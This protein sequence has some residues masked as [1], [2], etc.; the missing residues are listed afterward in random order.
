MP[1]QCLCIRVRL[2]SKPQRV[3]VVDTQHG[4]LV[5]ALVGQLFS[6]PHTA[7]Y[8]NTLSAGR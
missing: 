1:R 5:D 7:L 6:L 4:R 2:P 8:I 3:I